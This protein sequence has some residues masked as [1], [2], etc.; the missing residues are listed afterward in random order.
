MN[1]VQK[2]EVTS[3][4]RS[5][6]KTANEEYTTCISK[7]FLSKF[8]NNEPVKV[9]DFCVSERQRMGELDTKIYGAL[10]F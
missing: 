1:F 5:A 8:L 6:L 2:K 7:D 9:E 10:P 4:D 3:A